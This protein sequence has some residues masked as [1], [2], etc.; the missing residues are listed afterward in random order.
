M[1]AAGPNKEPK[2]AE[3]ALV[4]SASDERVLAHLDA[5]LA[6]PVFRTSKRCQELLR[7]VVEN[8]VLG[9]VDLLKERTIGVEVFSR[10]PHYEPSEDAIVR[11]NANEVRKRLAQYYLS[12]GRQGVW[13]E[14][15]AGTYVP[16]FHYGPPAASAPAPGP[17]QPPHPPAKR[18]FFERCGRRW[19]AAAGVLAAAAAL[20]AVVFYQGKTPVEEFWAPMWTGDKAPLVSVPIGSVTL[21]SPRL[22]EELARQNPPLSKPLLAGPGEIEILPEQAVSRL[23][24]SCILDLALFIQRHGR[25]PEVQFNPQLNLEDLR[26]RPMVLIGAFNNPWTLDLGRDV[27]FVF[28]RQDEPNQP[29]FAIQD[30][31]DPA[32]RWQVYR[33]PRFG[34]ASPEVDYALVTR[35]FDASTRQPLISAAGVTQR[36]TRAAVEFITNPVY[37]QELARTA[38]K[39]WKR[40]NLQVVMQTTVVGGTPKPPR[41]LATH[42]W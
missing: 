29:I 24:A 32:R 40:R 37:W 34:Y 11:V 8:A 17:P 39:D 7:F 28:E 10:P 23:T 1:P 38:P 42:F 9:R 3:P 6:S 12:A 4:R 21:L 36:G 31:K 15:P 13:I 2:P 16:E 26:S 33:Q 27:R 19:P 25:T 18:G 20:G 30:R 22:Q 5:V 14:L 35:I 41:V